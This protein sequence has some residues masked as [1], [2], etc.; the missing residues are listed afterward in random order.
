MSA[1]YYF[2]AGFADLDEKAGINRF[3]D[4]ICEIHSVIYAYMILHRLHSV[5]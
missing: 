2:N 3:R 4:K 5:R 1:N